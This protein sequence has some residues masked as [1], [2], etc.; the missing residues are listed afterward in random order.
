[1]QNQTLQQREPEALSKTTENQNEALPVWVPRGDIY[2]TATDLVL[3]LDVP[4]AT[5]SQVEVS[6]ESDLLTVTA[7][8]SETSREGLRLAYRE[9]VPGVWRREFRI[10]ADVDRERITA[11]VQ[12]GVLTVNVPKAERAQRR[13]IPVHTS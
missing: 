8:P 13:K 2:E 3:V 9:Y 1:M 10:S 7:T 11:T 4:G 6:L 12:G 5:Q